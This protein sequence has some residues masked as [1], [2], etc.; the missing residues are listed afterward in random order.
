MCPSPGGWRP[1]DLGSGSG[2]GQPH[3]PTRWCRDPTGAAAGATAA[4]RWVAAWR[5]AGRHR[6]ISWSTQVARPATARRLTGAAVCGPVPC[7]LASGLVGSALHI[8]PF[9]GQLRAGVWEDQVGQPR[10]SSEV[11]PLPGSGWTGCCVWRHP[12]PAALLRSQEER[13]AMTGTVGGE[14]WRARDKWTGAGGGDQAGA[15]FP[16]VLTPPLPL[17]PLRDPALQWMTEGALSETGLCLR[18]PGV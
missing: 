9:W 12:S 4:E 5:D 17:Q 7:V 13:S 8:V 18:G 10:P 16:C 15:T 14:A 6:A 1:R 2:V 3:T 11:S